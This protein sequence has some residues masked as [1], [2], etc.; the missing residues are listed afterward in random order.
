MLSSKH[1]TWLTSGGML[2]LVV[3]AGHSP[4]ITYL[5]QTPNSLITLLYR[6]MA[7][8][9]ALILFASFYGIGMFICSFTGLKLIPNYLK[10]PTF[11]FIGFLSASSLVYLLGFLRIL[12]FEILI[13]IFFYGVWQTIQN[14]SLFKPI[15]LFYWS[16]LGSLEKWTIGIIGVFL[17]GRLFPV[18]NFNSF[19]DPLT[20]NLP[21]GRDYLKVGG[22][23]WFE[24]AEFYSQAGLSDIGLIYL[25]C[26]T[27]HP[28]LVQLTA[29]SFYYLTG[30]LFLLLILNKGLFSKL[31][32]EKHSLWIAFSFIAMGTFRLE[33]IVAKPDYWLAVLFCLI[34]VFIYEILSEKN[35]EILFSYW[36]VVL[37]IAGL[38]LSVK[39]TS[40]FFLLPLVT[41]IIFF[42]KHSIPWR[43]GKF[44]KVCI[45]TSMFGLLNTIKN[46]YIFESPIFPFAN[47]IF[48]SKY[49]DKTASEGMRNL[50]G[51]EPGGLMEFTQSFIKFF[52]GH[53]VSMLLLFATIVWYFKFRKIEK[54]SRSTKNFLAILTFTWLIGLIFWIIFFTPHVYPRF[55]I[56]FVFLTLL[57]PTTIAIHNLGPMF[58][59][60]Y[61]RWQNFVGG[62][63]LLL[64][65]SV[66]H[67][68]VDFYQFRHWISSKSLHQ[69]WIE[70]SNLAEVQNYLNKNVTP[71]TR[72]LFHYTTQRFHS[73]FI[74][75]GARSFSPR[76]RFVYSKNK[77]EIKAGLKRINPEYYVIRKD[78]IG[79]SNALLA[80]KI[81]LGKNFKLL[82]I[83]KEFYLYKVPNDIEII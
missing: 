66:S 37:M 42:G 83:F 23:Q 69:Q 49:W 2:L 63:A 57:I 80:N 3:L 21:S 17:V 35:H 38:C 47:N 50:F 10:V 29:Q 30:T 68:D 76:T 40:I 15:R 7:L 39:P 8:L 71:E 75:Y 13:V 26:L 27:N 25:H 78:R 62:L 11:F 56:G 51:L 12:Y 19:G 65:L 82:K 6:L 59:S 4:T 53:P 33:S 32:P 72:V 74:V 73:N 18:L 34:L 22:F 31:V 44:W 52:A 54:I 46:I 64:T 70:N 9:L 67:M 14:K 48:I 45:A 28:M 61:Q 24:H 60:K 5:Y 55:I 1:I 20:Y 81:F 36:T 41:G 43:T 79:H 58:N 16:R 77:K